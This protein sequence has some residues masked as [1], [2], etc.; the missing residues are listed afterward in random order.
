MRI[1]TQDLPDGQGLLDMGSRGAYIL[2]KIIAR[3]DGCSRAE[4]SLATPTLYTWRQHVPSRWLGADTVAK[5]IFN[6]VRGVRGP[7]ATPP[8]GLSSGG[9]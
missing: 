9:N 1:P 5:A 6:V 7:R 4:K 8:L 3:T 2:W